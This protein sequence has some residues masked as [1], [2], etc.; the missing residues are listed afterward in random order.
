MTTKTMIGIL[1]VLMIS[2]IAP[3]ARADQPDCQDVSA[4]YEAA[5]EA[6]DDEQRLLLDTGQRAWLDYRDATCQL[7][8]ARDGNPALSATALADCIAFMNSARALELRLVARSAAGAEP[9]GLY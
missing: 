1:G 5:I 3:M 7:F 9:A 2:A 6:L 8:S 4:L